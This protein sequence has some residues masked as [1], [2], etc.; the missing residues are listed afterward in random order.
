MKLRMHST[1]DGARTS[2]YCATAPELAG[3]SGR[4]YDNC[5]ER[6]PS[7]VATPQL[8]KILWERSEAW[9]GA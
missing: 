2:L 6:E 5:A 1:E 9:T 8:A 4:F 7:K 3:V